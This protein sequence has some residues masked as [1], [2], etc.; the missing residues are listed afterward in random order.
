MRPCTTC[1]LF[2]NE[3]YLNVVNGLE[4]ILRFRNITVWDNICHLM[5]LKQLILVF[6]LFIFLFF[7]AVSLQQFSYLND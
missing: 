7:R 1:A 3:S 5:P 2:K 6:Y 4:I